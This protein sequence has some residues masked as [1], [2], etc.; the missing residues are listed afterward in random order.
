M[1]P[2]TVKSIVKDDSL[3]KVGVF[4]LEPGEN[5]RTE[6]GLY[7]NLLYTHDSIFNIKNLH[8]MS[9]ITLFGNYLE[10]PGNIDL[11]AEFL[12]S[13]HF[14]DFFSLTFRLVNL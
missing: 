11:V 14:N 9:D 2:F 4:G 1:S 7:V 10:S 5:F 3:A 13:Y 8:F 6:A 12:T